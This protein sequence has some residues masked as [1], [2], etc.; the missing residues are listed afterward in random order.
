M[1][2]ERT[3][4]TGAL[5]DF[6]NCVRDQSVPA[7]VFPADAGMN[8]AIALTENDMTS[9]PRRRGDAPQSDEAVQIVKVFPSDAGMNRSPAAT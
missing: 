7:G 5:F 3:V 2:L 9:V 6:V 1:D 4:T 8:R